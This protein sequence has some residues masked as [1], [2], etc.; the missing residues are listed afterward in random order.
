[1]AAEAWRTVSVLLARLGSKK[2]GD[3]PAGDRSWGDFMTTIFVRAAG[4][5]LLLCSSA[6]AANAQP[7][8]WSGFCVGLN[9]GYRSGDFKCASTTSR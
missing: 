5:A 3:S 1:V 6:I 9:T 7:Y 4:A 2:T 8:D